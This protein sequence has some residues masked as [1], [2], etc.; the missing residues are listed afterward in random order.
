MRCCYARL[1][2]CLCTCFMVL[3]SC[4]MQHDST[5]TFLRSFLGVSGSPPD[6]W[7]TGGGRAQ[8]H[9]LFSAF[10]S[11]WNMLQVMPTN[12]LPNEA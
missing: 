2:A 11:L 12:V 9:S 7:L 1:A 4:Y 5:L 3:H 10:Q 8:P 6:F